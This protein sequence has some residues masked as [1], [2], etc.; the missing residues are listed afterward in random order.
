MTFEEGMKQSKRSKG[1]DTD[2]ENLWRIGAKEKWAWIKYFFCFLL[3]T[4]L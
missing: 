1:I 3:L 4:I 2:T